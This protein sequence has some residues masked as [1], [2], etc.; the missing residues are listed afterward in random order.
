MGGVHTL[1]TP[2]LAWA[3]LVQGGLTD[4]APRPAPGLGEAVQPVHTQ[5]GEPREG[6]RPEVPGCLVSFGLL[7]APPLEPPQALWILQAGVR[8]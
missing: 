1:P 5:G 4:V 7:S 2:L 3:R 6:L 8:Q